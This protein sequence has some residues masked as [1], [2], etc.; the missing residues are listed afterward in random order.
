MLVFLF[1]CEWGLS[2]WGEGFTQA[3]ENGL[4]RFSVE[5]CLALT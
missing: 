3:R 4:P 5:S 2:T 1:I